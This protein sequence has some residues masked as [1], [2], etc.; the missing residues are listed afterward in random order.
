MVPTRKSNYL[1]IILAVLFVAVTIYYNLYV[2]ALGDS[3]LQE[4][5]Y[6]KNL[7]LDIIIDV[8]EASNDSHALIDA[9]SEIDTLKQRGVYCAAYDKNLKIISERHPLYDPDFDVLRDR[10]LQ[11]DV[12]LQNRGKT[13]MLI[14]DNGD[15]SKHMMYIY[16]RWVYYGTDD[17]ILVIL[18]MS[19]FAVETD[20]HIGL[21]IGAWVIGAAFML[22]GVYSI[23]L[24]LRRRKKNNKKEED[25]VK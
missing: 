11:R 9:V 20:H 18:G 2:V 14:V 5:V 25:E 4:E 12:K 24:T 23:S 1:I 21:A 15:A 8:A 13:N 3:Y 7:V 17:P 19:Q 22:L 16:F 6:V 10:D